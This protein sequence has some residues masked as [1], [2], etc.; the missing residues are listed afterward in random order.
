MAFAQEFAQLLSAEVSTWTVKDEH[1]VF[2]PPGS[3]DAANQLAPQ[4]VLG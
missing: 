1:S 3:R 2:H 4:K